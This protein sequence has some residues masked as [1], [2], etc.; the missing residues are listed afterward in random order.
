[1]PTVVV[2]PAPAEFEALLERRRQLGLDRWDEVWE[3]ALH[4]IPPPSYAHERIASLLHWLLR[5]YADAAGLELVGGVGL[6]DKDDNRVPDLVLQRPQE[7][8]PQWQETL[9][10]AVEIRSPADDTYNK[11]SFYADHRV[12][13]L[14]IVDLQERSVRW[15]ALSEG[16]Y[17]PIERS[18][19]ID[20]GPAELAQRIDWPPR[21]P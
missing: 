17:R 7:A 5:P 11:L 13:E 15:L 18:S 8:K 1:M 6:G 9:A 3:G 2:D 14:L 20:L 12:D 4:M 19:P 21:E 10:L 16:E